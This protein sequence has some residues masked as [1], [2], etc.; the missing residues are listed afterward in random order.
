MLRQEE[1]HEGQKIHSSEVQEG[2]FFDIYFDSGIL[3]YTSKWSPN[4][5][6]LALLCKEFE[7]CAEVVFV[8]SGC[9][10]FG[11]AKVKS[12]G[13]YTDDYV[14]NEFLDLIEY[15]YDKDMYLF[16]DEYYES[17]GEIVEQHYSFWKQ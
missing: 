10:I 3:H 13:T 12:D 11:W 14:D 8:E 15:D 17:I 4:L 16:M 5:K 1:K 7:V 2:Y 6:D 9:R